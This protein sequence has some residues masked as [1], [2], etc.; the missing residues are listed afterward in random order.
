MPAPARA[1]DLLVSALALPNQNITSIHAAKP[2][3]HELRKTRPSVEVRR[4]SAGAA[5]FPALLLARLRDKRLLFG[6]SEISVDGP[7]LRGTK[8]T[9]RAS[10]RSQQCASP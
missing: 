2:I 9:D 5:Q 10:A 7:A 4:V 6:S 8:R 1:A 3:Q